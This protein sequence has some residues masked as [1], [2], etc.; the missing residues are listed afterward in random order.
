MARASDSNECHRC[1]DHGSIR[2]DGPVNLKL[3]R[4]C[5]EEWRSSE[6]RRHV[7]KLIQAFL[8]TGYAEAAPRDIREGTNDA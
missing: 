2:V 8:A 7:Q 4:R 5:A 6:C 3:C 1:P